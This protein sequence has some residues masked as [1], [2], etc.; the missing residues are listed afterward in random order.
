MV[1]LFCVPG[2][3]ASALAYLP[4]AKL[5][6]KNIKLCLLE[7]AGRGMRRSE[8]PFATMDEVADDL[9]R[10]LMSQLKEDDDYMILGYCFGSV[11]SYELYRRIMQN[12]IKRP[13]HVFYCA[14]DPP[15]GNTY[16]TSLF[17]DINRKAEIIE[18]LERYFPEHVF[19]NR[20]MIKD[21]CE[22]YTE[23]CF[24]NYEKYHRYVPV[25]PEQIYSD[26]EMESDNLV[27]Q[28]KS[29]EFANHTMS[30][31][32]VDQTIVQSYQTTPRD[33]IKVDTDITVLAGD[34][35][36]MTPLEDVRKW[37]NMAGKEFNLE[38]ISGGHLIL[39]DGYKNCIPVINRTAQKFIQG[40]EV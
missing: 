29:F 8:K 31:F 12:G 37:E 33:F 4:W 30:L 36:T 14:S 19:E 3:A 16:S 5:L 13:F 26:E 6:D 1:K 9:Y 25:R 18:V 23:Q 24:R 34:R 27:N 2:G 35:D 10:N 15:D 39:V 21:F 11:A 28:L 7:V 17:S 40:K 20:E 38:V 22:K 32:D